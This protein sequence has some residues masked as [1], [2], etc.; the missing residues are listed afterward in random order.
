MAVRF[1]ALLSCVV[2]LFALC[3]HLA[4]AGFVD[5]PADGALALRRAVSIATFQDLPTRGNSIGR[6]YW[7][8]VADDYLLAP[9]LL[10]AGSLEAVLRRCA[11]FHALCAP[12]AF[13][14]GAALRRP[15]LGLLF[16]LSLAA[17]PDLVQLTGSY[18]LN[19]RTTHW[20]L[21]A[22]L[23]ATLVG[24]AERN[25]TTRQV[26][27]A[28]LL[29]AA[30]LAVASHPFGIAA[31]PAALIVCASSRTWPKGR[32]AGFTAL[33]VALVLIPYFTSN[34]EGLEATLFGRGSD[35]RADAAQVFTGSL[36]ALHNVSGAL[37]GLPGGLATGLVL[38]GGIPLCAIR[39]QT[40]P[41]LVLV[42]LWIFGAY[43]AFLRAGDPPKTWH[44][45]P[46]LYLGLGL[47]FAGWTAALSWLLEHRPAGAEH[48]S[49]PR[50]RLASAA[51][52]SITFFALNP[53]PI[54][55]AKG[56]PARG[57]GELSKAVLELADGRPFQY[58]EAQSHCPLNWSAEATLLDLHLRSGDFSLGTHQD[59]HLLA[60]IERIDTFEAHALASPAVEL[61][62]T[63]GLAFRLHWNE[64]PQA[65][66]QQFLKY[67][68]ATPPTGNEEPFHFG[69]PAK[70]A[71]DS[72]CWVKTACSMRHPAPNPDGG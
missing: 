72:P 9:F 25:A 67:C 61:A 28:I 65:W 46:C 19:Y 16:G 5:L 45:R 56:S 12:I 70:G 20:A 29:G 69:G 4:Q 44:R 54:A 58:I 17:L 34:L 49:L 52:I 60:A 23:G 47:G 37:K 35:T 51:L 40:R 55:E 64:Y 18:P 26:G 63:N 43:G 1:S 39:K 14:I 27:A 50:L 31:L 41:A 21:L 22:L 57:F 6:Y 66:R 48:V 24:S 33:G 30:A 59:A 62:L 15:L 13:A 8:G 7:F 11:M 68:P 2:Y 42:V 10:A 32:V 71:L 36:S 53:A 3:H 38:L